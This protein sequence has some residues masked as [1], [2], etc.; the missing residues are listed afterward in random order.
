MEP[1]PLDHRLFLLSNEFTHL[2]RRVAW[3]VHC[4]MTQEEARAHV[5]DLP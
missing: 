5:A 3:L 1:A 4:G 2:E